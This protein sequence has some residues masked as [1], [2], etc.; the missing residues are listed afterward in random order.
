MSAAGQDFEM[1]SNYEMIKAI[2]HGAYGVVISAHDH[3]SGNKVIPML[4][5]SATH[6]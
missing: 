1:R 3:V 5:S 2:G 6:H 4:Y